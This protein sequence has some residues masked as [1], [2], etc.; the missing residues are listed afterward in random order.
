M[1]NSAAGN[2]VA[3]RNLLFGILAVQMDFVSRDALIAGM[4]AW[5]L[6]K[7]RPFG[8]ILQEQGALK[9]GRRLLL[10]AMVNE[11][12]EAHGGD[13][14][15]S[16]AAVNVP[17]G[18]R[19]ELET[20]TDRDVAASLIMTLNAE[21]VRADA[22]PRQTPGMRYEV[23]RPHARGGLGLVSV[24]R[25]AELGREVALKKIQV[26]HADDPLNRGRFLREAEVTGGLE[27]PGIVPVYG[28]GTHADERPFY[29]MRFV[30]DESLEEAVR[31]LHAGEAGF[32]FRGLLTRFVAVCN[33]V[34]YA[35][36]RGVIHR[37]LKPANVMLGPYARR[38]W[39]TGDSPRSSVGLRSP[40][41]GRFGTRVPSR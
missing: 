27:H 23:L 38:W 14:Q 21:P 4:N 6:A 16:L 40:V 39:S 32:T 8:D 35:H 41:P 5:V 34:A 18:V 29:A 12:L 22:R 17:V 13:V 31:K 9:P 37:D 15:R 33:A 19:A 1:S 3:D 24:A 25:D 30:R 20:L 10:D 26:E 7:H 2:P 36:S 28:L 11:H